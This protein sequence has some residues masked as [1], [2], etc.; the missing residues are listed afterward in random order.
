MAEAQEPKFLFDPYLDWVENEGIPVA[1]DFG[2]DLMKVETGPWARIDARGAAVH[3]KGRGDYIS[4]FL[5]DI[6]AGSKTSPQQHLYEEVI[7][8]LEGH[9]STTIETVDGQKHSFEWGPKSLFALPLNAKY[10]HFN[11][12][13]QER[14]LLSATNDLC[15]VLNLFHNEDFVFNNSFQFPERQGQSNYFSG[16]GDF[17]PKVPG[18]HM[19][20]TNFIP[21]LSKFE[22]QAWD[23]RGAGSSNM[24]F[25]LADGTM[26]AHSSEMPVGTY[27]KAHRHGADFHVYSVT[28]EG[29]SLLWY[30]EDEEFVRVDW[31]HGVVFA[32][33]DGMYHQHY[34]TSAVPARYLAVALGSLRYPFSAEKM[35]LFSGV[36]V[37]VKDGGRQIEYEDQ[38]PRVHGI[39]LEEI[40]KNGVAS[41]MGDFIDETPY[42]K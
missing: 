12:S 31:H 20:E 5:V 42:S 3:L 39:F 15:L 11:S 25:I 9:G 41:G 2:I 37:S 18:R 32:P 7:Y 22:L 29:Y 16:E 30:G 33:P 17:I 21:D 1:E 23:K 40:E 6:P 24:K 34:N 4:I 19:W 36:D 26:H 10:Q 35:G 27:K 13:G 14:A 28:G 38:D 8:V